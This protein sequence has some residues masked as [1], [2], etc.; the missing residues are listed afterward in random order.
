[1]QQTPFK[2]S[3][4]YG[5]MYG[6]ACFAMFLLTYWAGKNPLGPASWLSVWIPPLII[7]LSIR[8]YRNEYLGGNI[9]FY[10]AFRAG[11]ITALSGAL[12]FA[13]FVLIFGKVIDPGLIDDLKE[14]LLTD[15]EEVEGMVK[16]MMGDAMYDN[17]IEEIK[18]M[19]LGKQ[20]F[21]EFAN[22]S[23]SGLVYSLI[24]AAI[25]KRKSAGTV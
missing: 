10:E 24:A 3:V 21:S 15:L 1:M 12:L 22:K 11:L 25:L 19:T 23:I 18:G 14:Q 17:S 16:S 20:A 4:N 5:A 7:F 6:L 8:H 9:T 13:L 2:S